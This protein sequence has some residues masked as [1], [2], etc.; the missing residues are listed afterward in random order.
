M[1]TLYVL[2]VC[3]YVVVRLTVRN[4]LR[5]VVQRTDGGPVRNLARLKD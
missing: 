2:V 5:L 4:L 3:L 1:L